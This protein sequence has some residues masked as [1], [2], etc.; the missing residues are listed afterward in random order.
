MTTETN[1]PGAP[2]FEALE[3]ALEI[4]VSLRA[5]VSAVRR[6]DARLAAQIVAAGSSIA[7]NLSE[8]NR[9]V[10]RDR[11]HLFRIAAG[12]ADE[13]RTHLRVAVAWGFVR[14]PQVEPA[15]ALIDRELGMIW[16]L[17]H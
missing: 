5:V 3:L 16:A 12:S 7:A 15:M 13:T 2:R 8:G 14:S 10:G 6:H 1:R 17:T 9:R 11:L 4:I